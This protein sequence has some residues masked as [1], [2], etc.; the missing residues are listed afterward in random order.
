MEP[1]FFVKQKQRG[2]EA[3]RDYYHPCS[4]VSHLNYDFVRGSVDYAKFC[5]TTL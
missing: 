2:R 1:E 4:T 3:S 5:L